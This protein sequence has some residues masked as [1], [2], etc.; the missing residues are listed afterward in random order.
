[1]REGGVGIPA[2]ILARL[3]RSLQLDAF[4]IRLTAVVV[5]GLHLTDLIEFAGEHILMVVVHVIEVH[6]CGEYGTLVVVAQLPVLEFFGFQMA[7]IVVL[8]VVA[9]RL[10]VADGVADIEAVVAVELIV[11]SGF[12]VE[13]IEII[14]CPQLIVGV[15]TIPV[16][17]VLQ[18]ETHVTVLQVDVGVESRQEGPCS[19]A[20][21]VEVALPCFVAVILKV[22]IHRGCGLIRSC[23]CAVGILQLVAVGILIYIIRCSRF[24]D[25]LAEVLAVVAV[26]S[27]TK[28]CLQVLLV[29]VVNAGDGS[30]EVI[31]HLL[32]AYEV[33]HDVG[34]VRVAVAD[35][36]VALVVGSQSVV[37]PSLTVLI[38]LVVA[39]A[40][41]VVQGSVEAPLVAEQLVEDELIVLL[42]VV[43]GLTVVV[44][45]VAV[46]I[47]V[48][49][50]RVVAS[51][52]EA[53]LVFRSVVP[54]M[55]GA[56]RTVEGKEFH[57]RV[58][59]EV[60]GLKE[61][62]VELRRGAVEV[63]F[64]PDV[65]QSALQSPVSAKQ[66]GAETQCL[67][68]A[69][70]RS[71]AGVEADIGLSAD[72]LGL[73][74]QRSTEGTGAVGR[75]TGAALYLHALHRRGEVGHVDEVDLRALC[76]VDRHAVGRDVDAAGIHATHADGG[77]ANAVAG[78]GGGGDG[79]RQ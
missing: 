50:A 51:A 33:T 13:E 58:V 63:S 39:L 70:V 42:M 61:V 26:P 27:C 46:L 40:L 10:L 4:A 17:R 23:H 31:V 64:R 69:V 65:R 55:V 67:L 73:H 35:D 43:V 77:V 59:S 74:V 56:L 12:R 54:G 11:E 7:D 5:A 38:L 6:A 25:D 41:G 76:V 47:P 44:L 52:V 37:G 28:C 18:T 22:G 34:V 8:I 66:T 53:L 48:H 68:V 9:C 16:A 60:S 79:G 24:P 78:V 45:H 75:G 30:V 32:L 2:E 57:H 21:D 1:M 49:A 14:V 62:G 71:C 20:V 19:L 3:P 29:V 72:V 15:G 36:D